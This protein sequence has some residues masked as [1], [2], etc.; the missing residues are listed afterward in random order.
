MQRSKWNKLRVVND[1]SAKSVKEGFS[2][3]VCLH[4]GT[5]FCP[6]LFDILIKFRKKRVA[7]IGDIEKA[8]L[9]IEVDKE[10]RDFLRFLWSNNVRDF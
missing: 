3:N 7:L 1:V 5:S 6:L 2:L 4:K 8:F 10:G 9:N